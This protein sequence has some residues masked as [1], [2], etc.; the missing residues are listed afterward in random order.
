MDRILE[1]A[2]YTVNEEVDF[3]SVKIADDVVAMIAG[4]A[5]QEVEG[6]GGLAGGSKLSN[7]APKGVRVDINDGKV[8]AN[9]AIVVNY[10]YN[11]PSVSALVQDKVSG[12]IESMTGLKATDVNIRVAGVRMRSGR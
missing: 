11:I 6:V 9:L 10:G 5:A 1:N 3:G 8:K 2:L 12:A 4:L 7:N